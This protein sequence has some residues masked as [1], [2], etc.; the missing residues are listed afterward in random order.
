MENAPAVQPVAG[1]DLATVSFH[2]DLAD[3]ET[4][5]RPR[6]GLR[7]LIFYAVELFKDLF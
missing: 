1:P 3:V 2:N 5:A 7:Q 4:K 6:G